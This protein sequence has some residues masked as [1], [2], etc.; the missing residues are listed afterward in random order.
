M[1]QGAPTLIG[2]SPLMDTTDNDRRGDQA[3]SDLIAQALRM[4]SAFGHEAAL[5]FL[6]KN[7]VADE[8]ANAVLAARHGGYDRRQRPDT[9]NLR[10]FAS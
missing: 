10:N 5:K 3:A 4:Q 7:G 6:Q 9:R 8:L 2:Y 1:A